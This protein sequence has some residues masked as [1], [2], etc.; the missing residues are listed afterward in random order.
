VFRGKIIAI[1][2]LIAIMV[3]LKYLRHDLSLPY[4]ILPNKLP[5]IYVENIDFART[6]KGREW[7]V[8]AVDAESES[9]LIKARS[10][11][12]NMREISTDKSA[13]IESV[14]GEYS[15]DDSKMWLWEVD[16]QVFWGDRIVDISSPRAD[17]DATADVWFFPDG[18]S[19]S[20][21]KIYVTGGVA[22]IDAL[23]V[24]SI[25]KGARVHWVMD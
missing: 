15:Q 22:N 10:M 23:G 17:Y 3:M 24:L 14:R 12:V 8:L 4:G 21:D 2:V 20:D 1:L 13:H 9:G 5:D 25:G 7:H 11:D 19:A 16:G 6:I 18:L